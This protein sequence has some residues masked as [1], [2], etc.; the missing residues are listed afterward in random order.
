MSAKRPPYGYPSTPEP[1][2]GSR[3]GL[4]VIGGVVLLVVIAGIVLCMHLALKPC[5]T[6]IN[7]WQIN[8]PRTPLHRFEFI[9]DAACRKAL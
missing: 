6:V 4:Y 5:D 2:G 9:G 8:V 7:Q 1:S 3:K